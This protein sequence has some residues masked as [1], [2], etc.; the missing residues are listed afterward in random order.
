MIDMQVE[1]RVN[2]QPGETAKMGSQ[3]TARINVRNSRHRWAQRKR[4]RNRAAS[5]GCPAE[6]AEVAAAPGHFGVALP[7]VVEPVAQA[8]IPPRFAKR[9]PGGTE[10][11]PRSRGPFLP[12]HSGQ[13]G[14]H[15]QWSGSRRG[16][17]HLPVTRRVRDVLPPATPPRRPGRSPESQRAS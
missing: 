7:T 2:N 14:G 16:S 9:F 1:R 11:H 17:G 15:R 4:P 5:P 10:V 6:H 8:A 12:G 13:A 3:R